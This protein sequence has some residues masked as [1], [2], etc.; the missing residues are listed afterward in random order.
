[1]SNIFKDWFDGLE[2]ILEE[3]A[4]F[5][6]VL[7]HPVLKGDAREFFVRRVLGSFLPD[8]VSVGSGEIIS[9]IERVKQRSKQ[10]DVIIFDSRFPRLKSADGTGLYP[11]EGTIATIEVKSILNKRNLFE[12]LDNCFSVMDL[13]INYR[14]RQETDD[15]IREYQSKYRTTFRYAEQIFHWNMS[16]RTYIFGFQGYRI[17]CKKMVETIEEWRR[18][19]S[20]KPG[21]SY[22]PCLP[23]LILTEGVVGATKDDMISFTNVNPNTVFR[24]VKINRKLGLLASHLLNTISRRFQFIN[25]LTGREYSLDKY[26]PGV[27]YSEDYQNIKG[28]DLSY[29]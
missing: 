28:V 9:S 11:I 25:N 10:I 19:K 26:N 12:A 27:L 6:G 20:P 24:A 17:K 3:E 7:E 29:S 23:R 21:N 8:C 16:P 13:P 15:K 18:S 1:M 2:K 4:R 5:A 22:A 14:N